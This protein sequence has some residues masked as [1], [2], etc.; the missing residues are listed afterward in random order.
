M[1]ELDDNGCL[2]GA[3]PQMPTAKGKTFVPAAHVMS[4]APQS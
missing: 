2:P 1:R 3:K 4:R